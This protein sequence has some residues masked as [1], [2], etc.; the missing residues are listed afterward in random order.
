MTSPVAV[1]EAQIGPAIVPGD[2]PDRGDRDGLQPPSRRAAAKSRSRRRRLL[3]LLLVVAAAAY[4]L[5]RYVMAPPITTAAQFVTVSVSVGDIDDAVTAVGNL[6][7][8]QQQIVRAGPTGE[9][10][11]ILAGIGDEV[12]AGDVLANL[13]T[14]DLE[15][16]I[17]T[18]TAQLANLEASLAD[19]EAQFQLSQA[20]LVRQEGLYEAQAI[21]ESALQNARAQ[22]VSAAA[23]VESVRSQ[24]LQAQINLAA[25]ERNLLAATIVAPISGT[26][27]T[28][29]VEVGQS[30]SSGTEILTIADLSMMT[31]EAQVSEAD[32]GRLTVGM[33]AY[34]TTLSN[35]GRNW[36]G[37]LQQILPTPQIANNVVLYNL[38]FDVSNEDGTL[39]LGMSTQVFFVV[40]SADNVLTV[41]VAALQPAGAARAAPA[42]PTVVAEGVVPAETTLPADAATLRG[43]GDT[44]AGLGNGQQAGGQLPAGVDPERA[45]ARLA[46]G[47]GGGANGQRPAGATPGQFAQGGAAGGVP[48]TGATVTQYSVRVLLDDGNVETRLVEIGARDR[49]NA[50]VISGLGA[51]EEVV[52]GTRDAAAPTT[53]TQGN[54]GGGGLGGGLGGL[55]GGRQF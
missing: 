51:G 23:S 37:T 10:S 17:Q 20:N 31:V 52:V 11:S 8:S 44:P 3:L 4:P 41:S 33:P 35:T 30:V 6:T 21:A 36:A 34:F 13:A 55:G 1:P 48:A 16:A 43:G 45:A 32:V 19:R 46:N 39:R 38:L 50:E 47:A 49:L 9:I 7:A 22:V 24:L 28:L 42:A 26:I 54:P 2:T 12:N 18:T 25:A 53:A 15:A 14:I 27:V 29:P 40:A 5:W